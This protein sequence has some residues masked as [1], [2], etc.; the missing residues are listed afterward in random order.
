MDKLGERGFGKV[1]EAN[2]TINKIEIPYAIK[3]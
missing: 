1:I 2:M 3:R